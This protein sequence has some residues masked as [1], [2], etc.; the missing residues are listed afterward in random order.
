ML[1]YPEKLKTELEITP[2]NYTDTPLDILVLIPF[3]Q[4]DRVGNTPLT[5]PTCIK[6]QQRSS[7]RA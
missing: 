7:T 1:N 4:A 5:I 3:K 2:N 6:I